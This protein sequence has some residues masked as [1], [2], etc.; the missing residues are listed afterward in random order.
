[1]AGRMLPFCA[2]RKPTKAEIGDWLR[3]ARESARDRAAPDKRAAFAQA[4]VAHTIGVRERAVR[5]WEKGRTTPPV[6]QFF[7]MVALYE[8]DVTDLLRP[9]RGYTDDAFVDVPRRSTA[10]QGG[11]KKRR[12][13]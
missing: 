3:Q 7:E 8:A 5:M 12:Q 2:V 13:A 11:G 4:E 10:A 9:R 6:H 1:M